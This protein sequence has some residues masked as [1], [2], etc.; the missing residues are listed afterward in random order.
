MGYLND[1]VNN[2]DN[3]FGWKLVYAN[4]EVL[5]AFE[6]SHLVL[7]HVREGFKSREELLLSVL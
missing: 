6:S 2:E 3:D 5:C 7:D 4:P 1:M